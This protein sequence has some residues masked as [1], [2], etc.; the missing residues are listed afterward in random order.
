MSLKS[1]LS[2]CDT[3]HWAPLKGS[4]LFPKVLY[5][6]I[7]SKVVG[8]STT[9]LGFSTFFAITFMAL[10]SAVAFLAEK[11]SPPVAWAIHSNCLSVF[12]ST[13]KPMTWVTKSIPSFSNSFAVPQG[14][15]SQ[16][17]LPSEI[18]I[19]VAFSSVKR[20]SLATLR[21]ERLIGVFPLGFMDITVDTTLF[22]SIFSTGIT[23]SISLQS[24]F[25]RCPYTVSPSSTFGFH[26]FTTF[27]NASLAI[28]ILV[29]PFI[30]P[31]MLPDASNMMTARGLS[32]AHTLIN[33]VTK[34]N[35]EPNN[36]FFII[37]LLLICSPF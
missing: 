9:G 14:S 17:S 3:F 26:S 22:L 4:E 2:F 31:H 11:Y 16:V 25:L 6:A 29:T 34:S 35:I 23:V 27:F 10:L 24:P 18:R 12:L 30:C 19:I 8:F 28:S 13:L 37:S 15:G 7:S 1:I 33:N 20:N 21:R 36:N 32:S 5:L